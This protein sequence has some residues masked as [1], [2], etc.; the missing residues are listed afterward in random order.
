[1]NDSLEALSGAPPPA[2]HGDRA[3]RRESEIPNRLPRCVSLLIVLA[4]TSTAAG[5]QV[6]RLDI[7]GA[8]WFH[9]APSLASAAVRAPALVPASNPRANNADIEAISHLAPQ[10]QIGRASCRERV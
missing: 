10:Q 8:K 5:Y 3:A 9:P 7:A 1:M 4:A 2:L 6:A